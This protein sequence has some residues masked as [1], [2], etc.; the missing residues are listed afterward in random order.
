[1]PKLSQELDFLKLTEGL[2]FSPAFSG[3]L[4]GVRGVSNPRRAMVDPVVQAEL[5]LEIESVSQL[6]GRRVRPV[7]SDGGPAWWLPVGPVRLLLVR[8]GG[9]GS[10]R[11]DCFCV[12]DGDE[13]RAVREGLVQAIDCSP[14]GRSPAS[15]RSS[16]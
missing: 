12:E 1:M 3:L 9:D 13:T 5:G 10:P 11:I 15:R 6:G 14:C 16:S 2:D 4:N 8:D 7:A